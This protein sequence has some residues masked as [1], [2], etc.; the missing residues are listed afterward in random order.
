MSTIR[1]F[2]AT[3][4]LFHLFDFTI[5]PRS[6]KSHRPVSGPGS[7]PNR[8]LARLTGFLTIFCFCIFISGCG[9]LSRSGSLETKATGEATASG[10]TT[11]CG[12][13]TQSGVDSLDAFWQLGTP[14]TTG[15]NSGGYTVSSIS[16]WV[17]TPAS[18]SFN[19]G[20]YSNSSGSPGS[21]LCSVSTGT[22]T[23]SSGWNSVNISN[24]PTLSA[25]TTYW[26]GYITGSNQ[27]EQGTVSGNCPGT[28][29]HSTW[30][31]ARLSGVSLANPFPANT[32]SSSCYSLY[33]TLAPVSGT[34]TGTGSGSTSSLSITTT[35]LP[36]VQVGTAYGTTLT[37]TGGT[38]P[39][40]W[41]LTSGTLPAGLSLN[42]STGAITGTPAASASATVLTF[43]VTD[44]GS[45]AQTRSVTFSLAVNSSQST[46]NCGQTTQSGVDSLDAFWQL[47][48]PCTTGTNSGGYT[49]SSI[50]YWVGT[51]ASASFNLG[52][53]SNSSGTPS[54]LLCSVSTGTI[55][56]S[57]GWNSVNIS[58]CPTL[59][60][61]TTYWVGYI[62]GSNQVEQGTVSGN[63][64]GTSYHST[65]TN[66]RS[67]GVSLASP[68]PAN[69][70][71]SSCYSL[72]M[73]LA[74]A[75]GLTVTSSQ[76]TT[77]CGQTT[78]SGVDSL[79]AFWQL[80]TPCTTG[81]NS[82]GYAVSSI[83]YWVGTPASA[84][85]NLGVYSNSSG[86]PSS[87]LCSVSTGTIA[88]SSGWNSVNISNCPKL[89]ASTT[90]WVGYITGS[91][92][93]EQGTVSGNCPGTSY[94]STWTNTRLSGV[95][96]ASP[97]PANTQS[98]SC[99]SLYMTL[100]PASGST[101]VAAQAHQV[102]LTWDASTGS[103]EP[104]TGYEIYRSTS[105]S[106]QYQ[107]LNVSV[108]AQTTFT[109]T[110]VQSGMTYLY[111][112]TAVDASG[113]QSAP[114]NIIAV[115]IP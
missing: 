105:G 33:M 16:Y 60:A 41:S 91:N 94:H 35:S 53:Y 32:Q 66:T 69:T 9:V 47:G 14:C 103:G 107:L 58:N 43:Q 68:F 55:T 95:S 26:V 46:T 30:T 11:N 100:N 112:V 93:V 3:Y 4:A 78:Q 115:A 8:S 49:V 99:Y 29:Y 21:L 74:P 59:S 87:L 73:T 36:N 23:P 104:I 114:S 51:P 80:G 71:S 102:T 63:C 82:G 72:Y 84:S 17:G 81:T 12:Q 56:P 25:S 7:F 15:T 28:S 101:Q 92:Q 27:V 88:P 40:T 106:A 44:S 22:L 50:S 20:V 86:T 98:S 70:Q 89:N 42:A 18:A 76:S 97:F 37:A 34:G 57:S 5:R 64:P 38:T 109:D 85:F 77:S 108:D 52:V 67:S 1:V 10:Q 96:L 83:S 39:Y 113:V 65:W 110:N 61:S 48:T 13:T 45:P 6:S 79:D 19:L 111:Y 90:Y 75:S 31:N 24:C 62:T 54:S 2:Y